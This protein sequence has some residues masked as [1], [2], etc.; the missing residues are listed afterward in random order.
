MT[1]TP[2]PF[3]EADVRRVEVEQAEVD[4]AGT[5]AV[6]DVRRYREE[7]A[8]ADTVPLAVTLAE[9]GPRSRATLS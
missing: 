3:D 1:L 7:G 6:L 2:Q 8:G 4:A 5:E 9:M